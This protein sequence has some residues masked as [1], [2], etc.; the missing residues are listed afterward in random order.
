[1]EADLM[2]AIISKTTLSAFL[3]ILALSV[4]AG[5]QTKGWG[6]NLS[7]QLGIGN[8]V[9]PQP[10]PVELTGLGEVTAVDGNYQHTL[11]LKADGT[12]LSAGGNSAGELG[13]GTVNT[14]TPQPVPAPVINLSR[15]TQVATGFVHSV[16][17]RDDGTVWAWGHNPRGEIGDGTVSTNA[18]QC[19]PTPTQA[20]ISNVV[21]IDAGASFTIALKSDGTVWGWGSSQNGQLGRNDFFNS[22]YPTPVQI[23]VGIPGFEDMIAISASETSAMALKSDGTVW[24]WGDNTAG[25]MGNGSFIPT[26]GPGC[27]CVLP[28]KNTSLADI[29]QITSGGAHHVALD[30][31][32][33][34][35]TWGS[36]GSGQ[37]GNGTFFNTGC[38]CLVTPELNHSLTN[39][40]DIKAGGNNTSVRLQDG[41]VW[42]W[43]RNR[44]GE[45]GNGSI[46]TL[47][48]ECQVTPAQAS[49][50]TGNAVIGSGFF[51]G[52]ASNPRFATPSA[53][54]LKQYGKNVNF[55][56][57]SVAVAGSTEYTAIDPATTGL[58]LP[59]GYTIM[60]D[61]P[62][63][64]ISSTAAIPGNSRVCFNVSSEFNATEFALLKIVHEEGKG[65]VDRTVSSSFVRREICSDV[66]SLS[67][68]VVARG[69]SPTANIASVGGRVLDAAGR[70]ILNASV[71]IANP[72][73]QRVTARTNPFGYYSFSNVRT[74]DLYT[75][76]P[77]AKGYRFDPQTITVNGNLSDM[78]FA[79]RG[80]MEKG[81]EIPF[82]S[83][84][85]SSSLFF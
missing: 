79:P 12:V 73:G 27:R 37:A 49:V 35:W 17:V 41:S 20:L 3:L 8:R 28:Q 29:I 46:T 58:S 4:A 19:I 42:A 63:Y 22:T 55:N 69:T 61:T 78:N 11:F 80:E 30:D 83:A 26:N 9:S 38:G 13:N 47:G 60:D 52:Y 40:V 84:P 57:P 59:N 14:T 31:D 48:C 68:F 7:G 65:L 76:T 18:C 85:R 72:Q 71:T 64:S 75:L 2:N 67:R 34:I 77:S 62:A 6:L 15:I 25:Q 82:R 45:V 74:I 24:V 81:S 5:A 32:G 33:N 50:G 16:A 54:N 1:M 36:N 56:F 53:T 44:E 51:Y 23:G 39:V 10:N 43:G 21:Q 66:N 70:A